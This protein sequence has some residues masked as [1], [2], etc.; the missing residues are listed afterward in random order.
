MAGVRWMQTLADHFDKSAWLNPDP[1]RTWR[2]GTAEML[3]GMFTMYPLTLEGLGEAMA[4]LSKGPAR[5][6]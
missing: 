6:R 1:P 4:H 2:G 3:A 5:R